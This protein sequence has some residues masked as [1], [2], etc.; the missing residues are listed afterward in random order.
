MPKSITSRSFNQDTG[1]AKRAAEDG[2]VFIT[3]RGAPAHVLMTIDDY[4]RLAERES[5]LVYILGGD[6]D[7]AAVAFDV[8]RLFDAPAPGATFD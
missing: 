1:A 6:E 8:P 2:P 7:V 5:S 3:D 4:R